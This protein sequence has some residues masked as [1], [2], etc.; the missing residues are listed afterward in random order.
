MVQWNHQIIANQIRNTAQAKR[1]YSLIKTIDCSIVC[2]PCSYFVVQLSFLH[3]I[4]LLYS[5]SLLI[6]E[7]HFHSST[8]TYHQNGYTL[9]RLKNRGRHT[10]NLVWGY[11]WILHCKN[12]DG[13]CPPLYLPGHTKWAIGVIGETYWWTLPT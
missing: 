6:S 11:T 5:L 10:L 13:Q 3:F 9:S 12:K 2:D 8:C 4:I 1:D 7:Q